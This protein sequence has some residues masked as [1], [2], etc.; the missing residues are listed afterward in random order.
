MHFAD[1]ASPRRGRR[2]RRSHARRFDRRRRRSRELGEEPTYVRDPR[3]RRRPL[4]R[5][6]HDGCLQDGHARQA[7]HRSGREP[8]QRGRR[9]G[10]PRAPTANYSAASAS[11]PFASKRTAK[12][13]KRGDHSGT[14]ESVN[15]DLL[16]TTLAGGYTP[17]VSVPGAREGEGRQL[18]CSQRRRRPRAAAIAGALEADLVVLTDVSGIYEDPDD[19]STKI[20]S[21]STPDEF[22]AVKDAAEG[23]MKKKVMARR[24]SRAARRQLSSRPRTPTNRSPALAGEGTT[25]SP[26]LADADADETAQEAAE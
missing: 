1:V 21:A 14:I 20:E 18:Y 10:R 5:R 6:A 3:R 7:Q 16:E 11:P 12:K 4:H 24:P 9:R 22:E 25:S 17:V 23:F 13:I 26:A 2:R 8:A 19:E 15:A